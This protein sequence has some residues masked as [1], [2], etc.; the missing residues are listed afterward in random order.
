MTNIDIYKNGGEN[1]K[2]ENIYRER[3]IGYISGAICLILA[4]ISSFFHIGLT[5]ILIGMSV[6][7]FNKMNYYDTK[8]NIILFHKKT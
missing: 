4:C 5:I 7:S 6:M 3:S 2:I 1:L 8:R